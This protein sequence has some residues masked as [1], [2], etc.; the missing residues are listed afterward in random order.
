MSQSD[1]SAHRLIIRG[2]SLLPIVQGGMGVGISAHR[3][4]GH[5][6]KEGA[7]G[8]ISSIDLRHHHED[9]V[10]E[11]GKSRDEEKLNRLNLIA[12]DREIKA[13]KVIANGNGMIAVNVMK[14]VSDHA[15]LVR[16]A[17][18]SGADAVV[19]GAG[20][21]V[22]L[23]DITANYPGTALIPILS[24]ARGVGVI[25]KKWM[26][27]GR[28]PDA[29]VIEHPKYAAGHLGSPKIE[30]INDPK[31]DFSSVLPKIW[32]LFKELGLKEKEIPIIVAGGITSHEH[33]K[34]ALNDLGA[35][36]V[37]LGTAFAVTQEGDAHPNFKD[38]LLKANP[39]EDL[40]TFISTSGFPA[41]G[42][43]TRWLAN[44]LRRE[45]FLKTKAKGGKDR[46][47]TGLQCLTVCGLRDGLSKI[48]QFC[49][50]SQLVAALKGDVDRG[51]FFRGTGTLPFGE[52]MR[53]VKELIDY[54]LTGIMPDLSL[55]PV[56][57][58]V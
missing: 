50:D 2:H 36:A 57:S 58:E 8:T 11:A 51:L 41:R 33:D 7:L 45:E 5:V 18:E 19:M 27:K 16:Q 53:S 49:I 22:D 28:L 10:A 4:A 44:Y 13:A 37:Q 31:Y 25:L 3:L 43:K 21:P 26:K 55:D 9:L 24:E 1:L 15:N 40:A 52:T 12:L 35:S 23:P 34:T 32:D 29:I 30:E 46:C 6:A 47:S 48:G 17:C 54:L 38:V 42:V 14:A 56:F 20:L 39:K